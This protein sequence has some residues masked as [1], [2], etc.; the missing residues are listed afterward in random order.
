M[1]VKN[2]RK[3]GETL[4]KISRYWFV[5]TTPTCRK[6]ALRMHVTVWLSACVYWHCHRKSTRSICLYVVYLFFLGY[7]QTAFVTQHTLSLPIL[8]VFP[9]N[10]LKSY[11]AIQKTSLSQS[12]KIVWRKS[13]K[14]VVEIY[15]HVPVLCASHVDVNDL[16]LSTLYG[17]MLLQCCLNRKQ[18][19]THVKRWNKYYQSVFSA[20]FFVWLI[21]MGLFQFHS[22]FTKT[23]FWHAHTHKEDRIYPQYV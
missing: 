12:K 6:F 1:P 7:F 2:W 13:K 10:P 14:G 23:I 11:D 16:I 15:C 3:I 8:M 20:S 17:R 5:G 22:P 9:G 4:E 19:K 18:N 21:I